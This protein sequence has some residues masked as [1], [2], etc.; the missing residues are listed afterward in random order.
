MQALCFLR[1]NMEIPKL[2]GYFPSREQMNE[3]QLLFYKYMERK[4]GVFQDS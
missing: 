2:E 3:E 1:G 4:F